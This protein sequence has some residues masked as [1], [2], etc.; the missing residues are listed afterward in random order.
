MTILDKVNDLVIATLENKSLV[1]IAIDGCS[2]SGKTTLASHLQE[3]LCNCQ[4]V[5]ADAFY[6]PIDLDVMAKLGPEEGFYRHYDWQRLRKD[7]LSPLLAGQQARYR[8]YDWELNEVASNEIVVEPQGVIIIEGVYSLF[9]EL[10]NFYDI[11]IFVDTP[12]DVRRQRCFHREGDEFAAVRD[13]A[14]FYRPPDFWIDLWMEAENWYL[15]NSQPEKFA[16]FV[17]SGT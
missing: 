10:R 7:L 12:A 13:R 8:T 17:V 2:G 15:A 16:D 3:K 6:I 11:S 9:S 1:M 14:T 4:V 5:H